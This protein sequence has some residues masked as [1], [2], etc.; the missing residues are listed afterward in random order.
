MYHMLFSLTCSHWIIS[1]PHFTGEG[2]KVWEAQGQ[3]RGCQSPGLR[4]SS[5]WAISRAHAGVSAEGSP[6][7]LLVLECLVAGFSSEVTSPLRPPGCALCAF[8]PADLDQPRASG[9]AACFT[10]LTLLSLL[11]VLGAGIWSFQALMSVLP[12]CG[13][14]SMCFSRV[15][16]APSTVVNQ[17]LRD[18]RTGVEI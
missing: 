8:I 17:L 7:L 18:L 12:R 16:G 1:S 6:L 4:Q 14:H 11:D 10:P 2:A 5:P 3:A 15:P 9:L 13:G